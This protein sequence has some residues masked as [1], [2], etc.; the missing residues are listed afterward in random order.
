MVNSR[1]TW[2]IARLH[3]L[4]VSFFIN[5]YCYSLYIEILPFILPPMP[6]EMQHLC[7][8]SAYA[9]W[10]SATQIVDGF[11]FR[12]LDSYDRVIQTNEAM[13]SAVIRKVSS[14]SQ[15]YYRQPR[16]S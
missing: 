11:V 2:I 12:K 8:V 7:V 13:V 1:L 6:P 3:S 5:T 16:F 4:D 10:V 9:A 14:S 15:V